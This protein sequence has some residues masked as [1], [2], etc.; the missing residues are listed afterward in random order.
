[1]TDDSV[2]M[3]AKQM[4]IM[5]V[6]VA[7]DGLDYA[8]EFNPVDLD[9]LLER[10]SYKTTKDSMHFSLRALAR[11]KLAVKG[12][13]VERRGRA[14]VTIFPTPLAKMV[15]KPASPKESIVEPEVLGE[16]I[17]DSSLLGGL[18]IP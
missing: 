9:M 16:I 6:I 12:A 14:R 4:E 11:R 17:D 13:I 5:K 15:M 3:T 1:M 8:G 2:R 10:L 18:G 7:G